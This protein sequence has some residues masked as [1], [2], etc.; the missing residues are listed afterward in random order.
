MNYCLRL[1][2]KAQSHFLHVVIEPSQGQEEDSLRQFDAIA[3]SVC[4]FGGVRVAINTNRLEGVV[5][6]GNR[7]ISNKLAA[8]YSDRDDVTAIIELYT[9]PVNTDRDWRMYRAVSINFI[10]SS[11]GETLDKTQA[12]GFVHIDSQF[13][14][15]LHLML[16]NA[17]QAETGDY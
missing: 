5:F 10:T 13:A 7:T 6:V 8:E 3:T 12:Y 14:D 9:S 11:D 15:A 17:A 16:N 1:P 2:N 4:N